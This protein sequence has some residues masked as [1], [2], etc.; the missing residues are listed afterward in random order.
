MHFCSAFIQDL[1]LLLKANLQSNPKDTS[2][3][4]RSLFIQKCSAAWFCVKPCTVSAA[5]WDH[6]WSCSEECPSQQAMKS[7]VGHV[8]PLRELLRGAVLARF[9]SDVRASR[10]L[11]VA[12][13]RTLFS[14]RFCRASPFL[15]GRNVLNTKAFDT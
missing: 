4:P 11:V 10:K 13:M 8:G 12:E 9:S 1:T 14:S 2:E 5:L 3:C 6:L 15:F 7:V